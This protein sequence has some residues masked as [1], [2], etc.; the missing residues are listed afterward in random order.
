MV[1]YID[2]LAW[3]AVN[4]SNLQFP[5]GYVSSYYISASVMLLGSVLSVLLPGH[6]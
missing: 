4:V 3:A 2:G 1:E 5:A 6:E